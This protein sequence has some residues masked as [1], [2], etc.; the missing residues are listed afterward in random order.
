MQEESK[1]GETSEPQEEGKSTGK[2]KEQAKGKKPRERRIAGRRQGKE[3]GKTTAREGAEEGKKK[4]AT[5][6]KDRAA[7]FFTIEE[8]DVLKR[9]VQDRLATGEDKFKVELPPDPPYIKGSD[10]NTN[11]RLRKGLMELGIQRALEVWPHRKIE[12]ATLVNILLWAFAGKHLDL[13]E[14]KVQ[15]RVKDQADAEK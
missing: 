1:P 2:S 12:D 5:E 9:I 4:T 10:K 13:E 6:G 14:L 8:I 11:I 7:R 3:E 15:E